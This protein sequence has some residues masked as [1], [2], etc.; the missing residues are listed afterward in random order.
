M[1]L[2]QAQERATR[3]QRATER[4]R[5][6]YRTLESMLAAANAESRTLLAEANVE[7]AQTAKVMAKLQQERDAVLAELAK[8]SAPLA[9]TNPD[10]ADNMDDTEARFSLLELD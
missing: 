6:N 1:Q 9:E 2:T 8:R 7:R 3:E 4:A 5:L 10:Q